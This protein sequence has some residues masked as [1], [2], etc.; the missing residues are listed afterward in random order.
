MGGG[1][2]GG[3]A[4]IR[5]SVGTTGAAG[6]NAGYITRGSATGRDVRSIETYNYPD[7]VTE[8]G[9]Y[10]E[11]RDRIVEYNRQQE[12]DERA[13]PH[14]GGGEARTHYRAVASF[15]GKVDTDKAREMGREWVE[16]NF[17]NSRAV[18]SVHQDT[19]HTHCHINIQARGTDGKKIDIAPKHYRNLDTDWARIYGR[20]F[21]KEKYQQHVEKKQE[22]RDYKRAMASGE[23]R[24]K[25][26]RSPKRLDRE[27][28]KLREMRNH[29]AVESRPGDDQR[30]ASNGSN[31][32]RGGE[33]ESGRGKQELG[34]FA[35][36]SQRADQQVDRTERAARGALQS[37]ERLRSG[38]DREVGMERGGRG[39]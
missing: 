13:R 19:N 30:A 2:S 35:G 25:P 15:E 12:E 23:N 37:V 21:G 17:P 26:E 33:Q 18:V 11:L 36:S 38:P 14:R 4:F 7:Y 29:G 28:Y 31:P 32:A 1:V 10:K 24:Q 34:R 27:A 6:A 16:R 20:E 3:G 22:T 5:F 9:D 8:A 39:R